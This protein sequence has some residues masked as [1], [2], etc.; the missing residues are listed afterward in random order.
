M[1]L[2]HTPCGVVLHILCCRKGCFDFCGMVGI[3]VDDSDAVLF[4]FQLETAFCTGVVVQTFHAVLRRCS[5]ESRCRNGSQCVGDVVFP[6]NMQMYGGEKCAVVVYVKAVSAVSF[7]NDVF[8]PPVSFFAETK[9]FHMTGQAVCQFF[10][11]VDLF[12]N[13]QQTLVR[14]SLGEGV[15]RTADVFQC[16]EIIQMVAFYVQDNGNERIELQEAVKVFAGFRHK[17]GGIADAQ[18]AADGGQDAAYGDGRVFFGCQQDFGNHGC[19]CGFAMGAGYGYGIMIFV[20]DL[21]QQMGAIHDS[22]AFFVSCPKFRVIVMDGC[23][24]YHQCDV[25]GDVFRAMSEIDV[26][27]QALQMFGDSCFLYIGAR[28]LMAAAGKNF[29]QTGHADA[30]DADKINMF[31]CLCH[32]QP[33]LSNFMDLSNYTEFRI[34]IGFHYS[35][36]AKEWQFFWFAFLYFIQFFL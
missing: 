13:H 6:G 17:I 33:P 36:P 21:P 25:I 19:G 27:A 15:E 10:H 23:G 8:R 31:F 4:P 30:A 7:M 3:V 18:I 1:R 9:C 29:R 16:F 11:I 24:V 12:G 14:Y 22:D 28:Y 20:H 2:E 26:D 32:N 35:I 34:Y 5:K